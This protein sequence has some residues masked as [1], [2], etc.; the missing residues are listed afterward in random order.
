MIDVEAIDYLMKVDWLKRYDEP[1]ERG[2]LV[3]TSCVMRCNDMCIPEGSI[4]MAFSDGINYN[5]DG[6]YRR[7]YFALDGLPRL[8]VCHQIY[9][10]FL[11]PLEIL[12]A[13]DTG[14]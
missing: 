10:K 5:I 11:S 8:C 4:G 9:L 6:R 3:K 14:D 1:P 13:C 7:V 2:R 12:A